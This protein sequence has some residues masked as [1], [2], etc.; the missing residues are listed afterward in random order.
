MKRFDQTGSHVIA[1]ATLVLVLGVVGFA[2][3]K[4]S[5]SNSKPAASSTVAQTQTKPAVVPT[6]ISS[7]AD[8]QQASSVLDQSSTQ[9]NSGLDDS[10]MNADLNSML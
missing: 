4:V 10:S 3:Y 8:L 5:Q 9:L 1:I 2:G 6:T 7:T